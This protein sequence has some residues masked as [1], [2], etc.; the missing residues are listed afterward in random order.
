MRAGRHVVA[1][2]LV[3]RNETKRGH[4]CPVINFNLLLYA[5]NCSELKFSEVHIQDPA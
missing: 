2:I 5:P 3:A 1:A 4:A